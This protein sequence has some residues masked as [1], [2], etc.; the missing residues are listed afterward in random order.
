MVIRG[1]LGV[2]LHATSPANASRSWRPALPATGERLRRSPPP[3]CQPSWSATI[4]RHWNNHF[5]ASHVPF[6][7]YRLPARLLKPAPARA[8]AAPPSGEMRESTA[9]AALDEIVIGPSKALLLGDRLRDLASDRR[10]GRA[11]LHARPLAGRRWSA[12][13]ARASAASLTGAGGP[14]SRSFQPAGG[15]HP[16]RRRRRR[17]RRLRRSTTSRSRRPR[18][19]APRRVIDPQ[20]RHPLRSGSPM[21]PRYPA[22]G[23]RQEVVASPLVDPRTAK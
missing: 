22:A 4:A 2:D 1:T 8:S 21:L 12:F 18:G 5:R 3:R 20:R 15:G 10:A 6:T 11:D 16:A 23:G 14:R 9:S 13:C 17:S 19:R 7:R